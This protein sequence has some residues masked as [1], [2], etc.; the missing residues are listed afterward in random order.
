[1][2]ITFMGDSL[3]WGKYGGDFV[4]EAAKL[5]PDHTLINAGVGGRTVLNLLAVLDEVLAEEPDLIFVMVGGNDALSYQFPE[6]RPYY[7]QVQKVPDG[8]VSPDL[9]ASSYRDL[10]TKIQLAHVHTAVGL[11]PAEYSPESVAVVEQYNALAREAAESLNIPVLDLMARLK[12]ASIPERPPLRLADINLIGAR[13]RDAWKAY[14]VEQE[15][16]GY[17]FTFDGLHLTPEAA[18]QVAG[19]IVEFLDVK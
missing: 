19:W 18:K 15:Q 2:K 1:M 11:P 10:L 14:G 5:L 8:F 9:F 3:T 12:P 7:K 16:G 17:T 4:A 13:V 6:L